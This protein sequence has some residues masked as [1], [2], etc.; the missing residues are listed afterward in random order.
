MPTPKPA[1]S[2]R[3]IAI[4]PKHARLQEAAENLTKSAPK[5]SLVVDEQ[6]KLLGTVS[7]GEFVEAC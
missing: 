1:N 5:I 3:R 2:P 4:I 7:N 6:E